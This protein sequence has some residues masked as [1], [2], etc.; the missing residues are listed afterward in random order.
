MSDRSP[1]ALTKALL[2]LSPLEFE[3][4][5]YELVRAVPNVEN[6]VRNVRF[7]GTEIDVKAT[8]DGQ[9]VVFE[10]KRLA[11][12]QIDRADAIVGFANRAKAATQSTRFVLVA[13]ARV[14][15]AATAVLR[16]AGVEFWGV[17]E[18]SRRT[19]DSLW[20]WLERGA[21]RDESPEPA[22]SKAHALAAALDAI[23]PGTDEALDF[24]KLWL[25]AVEFLFSPPLGMP[26]YEVSDEAKRNRRDI[27][28]ENFAE[29]GFWAV[30]R[31]EYVA[32]YI[33]VDAKNHT[34]PIEKRS[35]LDVS[36]YLKK[37]GCGLF[38][39]LATRAGASPAA[40]HAIREHWIAEQKMILVLDDTDLKRMLVLRERGADPASVIRE[41]LKEFIV[42]M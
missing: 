41:R 37:H 8:L 17:D 38:A 30:A 21:Q 16:T 22:R 26:Q 4:F 31:S 36:H 27:I 11:E 15:D 5:V 29:S 3:T 19:S 14:T 6:V 18:I 35:V 9:E 40:M 24:Q 12:I 20:C 23:H 34:D 7:A 32:R 10:T 28:I 2:A 39:L 33:V 13:P 25:D 42:S 1:T